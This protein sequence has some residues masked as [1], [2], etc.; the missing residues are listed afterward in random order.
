[1]GAAHR[2]GKN[3]PD[4]DDFFL[5]EVVYGVQTHCGNQAIAANDAGLR[6][7]TKVP[8]ANCGMGIR[9]L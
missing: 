1:M 7:M 4:L 9:V 3:V 5:V 8:V 6:V 2:A